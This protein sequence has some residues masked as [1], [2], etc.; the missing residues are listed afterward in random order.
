MLKWLHEDHRALEPQGEAREQAM[1]K[2]RRKVEPHQPALGWS[3][4]AMAG[5]LQLLERP[6]WKDLQGYSFSLP[7]FL[8]EYFASFSI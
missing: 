5:H 2:G 7:Y 1:G 8:R 6:W 3:S 4:T